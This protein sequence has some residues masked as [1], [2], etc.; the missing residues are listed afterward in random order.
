MGATGP[1]EASG[2]KPAV[3]TGMEASVELDTGTEV[4]LGVSVALE[5]FASDKVETI[6]GVT[7]L[8]V[9]TVLEAGMLVSVEADEV[10]AP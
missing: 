2:A 6:V 5:G 10:G 4:P 8:I 9:P 1:L 7:V 3:V